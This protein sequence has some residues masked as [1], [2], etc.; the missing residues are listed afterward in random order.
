MGRKNR[1]ISVDFVDFDLSVAATSVKGKEYPRFPRKSI[2]SFMQS[3]AYESCFVIV[4]DLPSPTQKR[5]GPFFLAANTIDAA[6][7]VRVVSISYCERIFSTSF[8][9]DS[10]AFGPAWKCAL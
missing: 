5:K 4:F 6:H 8:T 3:V 1:F 10:L 2:L 7:A 9:S